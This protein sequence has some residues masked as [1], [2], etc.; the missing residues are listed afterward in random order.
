MTFRLYESAWVAVEGVENPVL[1]HR[2]PS[3]RAAFDVGGF[4]YDIDARALAQMAPPILSILSVQ[5]V[6]EAG[7]SSQYGQDVDAEPRQRLDY[8]RKHP[9]E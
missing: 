2:D 3:N 6:R 7:L 4:S 1:V 5:A 9:H 8:R